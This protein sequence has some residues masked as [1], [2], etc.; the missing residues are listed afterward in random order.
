MG[1]KRAQMGM[2]PRHKL[3]GPSCRTVLT[4]QSANPSYTFLSVGWFIILVRIRSK[5]DW[6]KEQMR[7]F[8]PNVKLNHIV[9]PPFSP[10]TTVI[11]MKKPA[12]KLE[13]K[14]V[15]GSLRLQP[16]LSTTRPFAT[17]YTPILVAFRTIPRITLTVKICVTNKYFFVRR[18]SFGDNGYNA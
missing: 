10:L 16:V 14:A 15:R 13:Q 2:K 8:R 9:Q 5:G 1:A 7:N 12:K 4:K 18:P 11:V 6:R 17:S 3:K